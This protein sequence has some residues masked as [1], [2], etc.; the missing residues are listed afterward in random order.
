MNHAGAVANNQKQN[1]DI[2]WSEIIEMVLSERFVEAFAQ[3]PAET[4]EFASNQNNRKFII[5]SILKVLRD[6]KSTLATQESAEGIADRLIK[7]A[8]VQ[9]SNII[10]SMVLGNSYLQFQDL[11]DTF[12]FFK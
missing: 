1:P 8:K 2:S 11:D 12:H 3:I 10:T 9:V 6:K 4:I 5:R 7:Y